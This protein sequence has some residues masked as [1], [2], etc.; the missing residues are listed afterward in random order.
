MRTVTER[1]T[2][3]VERHIRQVDRETTVATA[4]AASEEIGWA[5]VLSGAENCAWCAMLASRGP[6]YRSDKSALTVV[7][8]RRGTRGTRE[9]GERYHDHCDC[10]AVLVREGQDWAGRAEFERLQRMWTAASAAHPEDAQ[11]AFNRSWRRIQRHPELEEEYDRLWADSTEG[12]EGSAALRAFAAAAAENPPAALDARRRSSNPPA[13]ADPA[14]DSTPPE[15]DGETS[16]PEPPR[17][18]NDEAATAE[19]PFDGLPFPNEYNVPGQDNSQ[20]TDAEQRALWSYAQ[21]GHRRVNEGR[22]GNQ[23]IPDNVAEHID[24]IR[25]AM[26]RFVLQRDYRVTRSVEAADL[27]ITSSDQV[28]DLVSRDAVLTDPAFLSTSGLRVP[29]FIRNR[30]DPVVLDIIVPEGT[31]AIL[32]DETLSPVWE[33]EHEL[34]LPESTPLQVFAA[35]YDDDLQVWRLS[36]M[37]LPE[38]R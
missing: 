37:V 31:H 16:P 15:T 14:E 8:G 22:R 19:D 9:L 24:D 27:G 11:R 6:V 4:N 34:L 2:A 33:H 21:G 32:M 18:D 28:V 38:A 26:D 12:L 23:D 10:D 35:R 17:D 3:T 5:R 1:V 7:G 29:P 13:P 20:L 30:S 25:S 36:A